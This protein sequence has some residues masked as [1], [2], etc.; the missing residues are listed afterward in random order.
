MATHTM[1]GPEPVNDVSVPDIEK[2]PANN[3]IMVDEDLKD[4]SDDEF[5]QQGVKKAEAITS[6]WT[7]K[8]L[9]A[10]FVL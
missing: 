10:T 7:K 3:N 6:V 8:M 4:F 1:N 5:K 2:A 9:I